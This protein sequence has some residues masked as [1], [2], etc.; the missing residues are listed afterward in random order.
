MLLRC[1][2]SFVEK[3]LRPR[4]PLLRLSLPYSSETTVRKEKRPKQTMASKRT[5]PAWEAPNPGEI[6]RLK[7]FNSL[8]REKEVFV[9]QQGKKV[10]IISTWLQNLYNLFFHRSLGITVAL[11]FM[12]LLTWDM[13]GIIFRLTFFGEYFRYSNISFHPKLTRNI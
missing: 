11:R 7:L 10:K 6:P 5:Q 1:T 13:H 9:P 4:P 12:M 2:A 8:T 3:L